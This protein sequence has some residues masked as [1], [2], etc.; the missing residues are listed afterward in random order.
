MKKPSEPSQPELEKKF[1]ELDQALSM[2]AAQGI[3]P[4]ADQVTEYERLREQLASLKRS[5]PS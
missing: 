1:R 5:R 3:E 4:P 2:L